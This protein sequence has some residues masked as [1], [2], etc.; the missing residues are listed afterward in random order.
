MY[1][2][3]QG[4]NTEISKMWRSIV[5]KGHNFYEF[6]NGF[7]RYEH[8]KSVQQNVRFECQ[9][10]SE[11]IHKLN[12]YKYFFTNSRIFKALDFCFQ[13]QI[14]GHSSTFKFCTNPEHRQ[15]ISKN[16]CRG[17]K[18]L[19]KRIIRHRSACLFRYLI[20]YLSHTITE[21]FLGIPTE[22]QE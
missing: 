22:A 1:Q 6:Q 19:A 8:A 17:R 18:L 13:I 10:I 21:T 14:Q 20:P 16:K 5:R 2:Q 7:V 12:S 11:N 4:L 9:T 3:I 15:L